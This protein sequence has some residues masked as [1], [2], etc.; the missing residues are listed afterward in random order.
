[1]ATTQEAVFAAGCFW[2]VEAT[3][4]ELFGVTDVEVGYTGGHTENPTYDEVCTDTTGHAEAVRIEFDPEKV[5]YR[6]LVRKFFSIHDPTQLDGQGL[7]MGR[8]YR[9]AIFFLNNE[10]RTIAEEEKELLATSGKLGEREVVTEVTP[11]GPFYR[12]EEYHQRYLE[13]RKRSV[14]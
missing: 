11:A 5:T 6:D 8:Q 13:A 1:M 9:S 10:Q 2:G 3:F 14:C 4:R 7:D 12:A